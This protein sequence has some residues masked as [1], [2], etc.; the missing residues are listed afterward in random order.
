[1]EFNIRNNTIRWQ[2]SKSIKSCVTHFCA[3]SYCFVMLAFEIFDI[4]QVGQD[5][6]AHTQFHN[7]TIAHIK[8]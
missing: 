5:H 6:G 1:M 7:Y 3:S 8:I 2:I 4:E